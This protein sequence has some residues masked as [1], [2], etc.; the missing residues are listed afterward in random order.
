[1]SVTETKNEMKEETA[2]EPNSTTDTTKNDE[3]TLTPPLIT[4]SDSVLDLYD[5]IDLDIFGD[6]NTHVTDDFLTLPEP[7]KWELEEK[8]LLP[9]LESEASVKR[10]VSLDLVTSV[11]S[12]ETKSKDNSPLSS[13]IVRPNTD[14]TTTTTTTVQNLQISVPSKATNHSERSIEI[15]GSRDVKYDSKI[16][17]VV[18]KDNKETKKLSVK[19]RLGEKVK[20]KSSDT[21]TSSE[22]RRESGKSL[23]SAAT[24]R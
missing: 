10:R 12:K 14:S 1:M 22:H 8:G 17:S 15:K 11:A 4:K 19:E 16:R 2:K 20:E 7:S 18:S 21:K 5:N 9:S 6:N 13:A 3:K 23:A 24:I